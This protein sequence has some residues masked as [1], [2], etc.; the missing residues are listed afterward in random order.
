MTTA[1][2]EPFEAY[3]HRVGREATAG[4]RE[5]GRNRALARAVREHTGRSETR[6]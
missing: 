2:G 6:R 5:V 4:E 1:F 3:H